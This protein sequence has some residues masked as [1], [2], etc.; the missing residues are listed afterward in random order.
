[1]G[2]SVLFG[3]GVSVIF[4]CIRY[5]FPQIP[6][7]AAEAGIVF[8]LL[9]IAVSLWP[10]AEPGAKLSG[11]P[12][13]KIWSFY[14]DH[15]EA[16]AA[17][18]VQPFIGASVAVSGSVYDVLGAPADPYVALQS[19]RPNVVLLRFRKDQMPSVGR[20]QKR[21]TIAAQCKLASTTATGVTLDRCYF[22]RSR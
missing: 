9:L 21:D 14:E 18:Y 11:I 4:A 5:R 17:R 6:H 16:E 13:E 7:R 8:G 20:L 3:I 22:P 12:T 19:D 15:T 1:M 10:K 2:I